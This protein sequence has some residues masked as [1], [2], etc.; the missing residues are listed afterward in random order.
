MD[1]ERVYVRKALHTSAPLNPTEQEDALEI[2][3]NFF[4]MGS[5][6]QPKFESIADLLKSD[7]LHT[8][9]KRFESNFQRNLEVSS[10]CELPKGAFCQR[11]NS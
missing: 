3:S 5:I 10:R 8:V 9:K 1:G 4:T 7:T 2:F 11:Q 6:G